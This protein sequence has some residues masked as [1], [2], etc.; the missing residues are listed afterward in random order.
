MQVV[1]SKTFLKQ[2]FRPQ[3]AS[4]G[5]E[6]ITT[7]LHIVG[8]GS[9]AVGHAI[10]HFAEEHQAAALAMMKENKSSFTKFFVGSVT[11]YC[12]VHSRVPVIIIP[13]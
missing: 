12:A 7:M 9:S 5:A 11:R 6:V 3:A 8:D 10:C 1:N 2:V 13:E 4:G